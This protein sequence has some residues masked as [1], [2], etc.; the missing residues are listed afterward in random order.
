MIL[1]KPY[2][3]VTFDVRDFSSALLSTDGKISFRTE[4]DHGVPIEKQSRI[5]DNSMF[6]IKEAVYK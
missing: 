3:Y 4:R 5:N 1:D 2:P 6:C